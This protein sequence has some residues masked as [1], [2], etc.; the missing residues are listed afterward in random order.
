MDEVLL[1]V[2]VES[3]KF[4]TFFSKC[5]AC[6]IKQKPGVAYAMHSLPLEIWAVDGEL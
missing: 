4:L 6:S 3:A 2:R 5:P 1:D